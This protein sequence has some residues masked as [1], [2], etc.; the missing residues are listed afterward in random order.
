ELVD[1]LPHLRRDDLAHRSRVL[2]RRAQA[3]QDRAGVLLIEGEEADDRFLRRHA[4]APRED[5]A[6]AGRVDERLPLLHRADRHVE[7]QVERHVHEARDVLR[8]LDVAAHPVDRIGDAAQHCAC[9]PIPEGGG[10][11]S[12]A[13]SASASSASTQVSLLPPPCEEFTTSEP[14]RNA[15]RVRPPGSMFTSD[16]VSTYGRRSTWRSLSWS[17]T[18]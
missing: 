16:P 1:L 4:V 11:V 2:A 8:A 17:P 12:I 5:V 15:T 7:D 10:T 3:R 18:K 14:S 6:V 9:V 13:A